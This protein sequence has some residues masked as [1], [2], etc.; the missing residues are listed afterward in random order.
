MHPALG[1]VLNTAGFLAADV[2]LKALLGDDTQSILK[3]FQAQQ[4]REAVARIRIKELAKSDVGR[5]GAADAQVLDEGAQDELR[6]VAA[7]PAPLSEAMLGLP[8]DASATPP[9]RD[10]QSIMSG[11]PS[12]MR[13]VNDMIG[14]PLM[15]K[16]LIDRAIGDGRAPLPTDLMGVV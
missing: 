12:V 9:G 1:W 7:E 16:A 3:R 13:A 15:Q 11:M 2:G 4:S 5:A 10:T 14:S 8:P 6:Q